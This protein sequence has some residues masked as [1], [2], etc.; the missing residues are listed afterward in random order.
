M[1]LLT[2]SVMVA[3][4]GAAS[5]ARAQW[6]SDASANTQI[7]GGEGLQGDAKIVTR[8]DDGAYVAWFASAESP[9]YWTLRLNRLKPTGL[10][11]WGE[12]VVVSAKVQ[13]T[14]NNEAAK[15]PSVEYDLRGD[16]GGNAMIAFTDFS[17]PGVDNRNVQVHR[18][19]PLGTQM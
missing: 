9:T 5:A 14:L 6:T 2:L 16:S 1:R 11:L 8:S 19:S 3:T 15:L 17:V 12:G 13:S 18:I 7:A 10:P 4:L